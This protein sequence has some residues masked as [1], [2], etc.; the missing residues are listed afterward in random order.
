MLH[1]HCISIFI[2]FLFGRGRGLFVKYFFHCSYEVV[3]T[4]GGEDDEN[5]DE[6]ES[7]EVSME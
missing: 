3:P 6:E 5:S 4:E 2:D 1:F 7:D